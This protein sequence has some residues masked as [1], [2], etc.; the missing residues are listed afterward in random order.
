[1][2]CTKHRTNDQTQ[3][4]RWPQ[5]APKYT[6]SSQL[7]LAVAAIVHR[8]VREDYVVLHCMSSDVLWMWYHSHYV[9]RHERLEQ[10][11]ISH[12]LDS[13]LIDLTMQARIAARSPANASAPRQVSFAHA[14]HNTQQVVRTQRVVSRHFGTANWL[15]ECLNSFCASTVTCCVRWKDLN[16]LH[17][18]HLCLG[19]GSVFSLNHSLGN[20]IHKLLLISHRPPSATSWTTQ[21]RA[22]ARERLHCC[23][24]T[25]SVLRLLNQWLASSKLQV[26]ASSF[27][28]KCCTR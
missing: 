14:S 10:L 19:F 12:S 11:L 6:S 3:T 28:H 4:K 20:R 8:C 2:C 26:S 15:L 25:V 22:Q 7:T 18:S 24:V 1:M 13:Y 17:F 21:T 27:A 16:Q 9:C 23:L 5:N